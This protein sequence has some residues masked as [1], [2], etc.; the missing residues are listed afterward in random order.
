MPFVAW[1]VFFI[2][3]EAVSVMVKGEVYFQLLFVDFGESDEGSQD[4]LRR[5]VLRRSIKPE[6]D[7]VHAGI[8]RLLVFRHTR[9]DL[10]SAFSLLR[11]FNA[12]SVSACADDSESDS[13]P[14]IHRPRPNLDIAASTAAT[15]SFGGSAWVFDRG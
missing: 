11:L 15:K 2:W 13:T 14:V 10:E 9:L 5:H 3:T 6:H 7:L 4:D 8:G 12:L 1:F